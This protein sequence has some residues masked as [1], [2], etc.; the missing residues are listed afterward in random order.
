[1][2]SLLRVLALVLVTTSAVAIVAEQDVSAA[3]TIKAEHTDTYPWTP[4][5][6]ASGIAC[7]TCGSS[8]SWTAT[9]LIDPAAS[10]IEIRTVAVNEK[11]IRDP[12]DGRL[13]LKETT[14]CSWKGPLTNGKFDR[15]PGEC[16]SAGVGQWIDYKGPGGAPQNTSKKTPSVQ[17]GT[18]DLAGGKAK[19]D[20]WDSVTFTFPPVAGQ[21]GLK[22]SVEDG[23]AGVAADGRSEITLVAELPLGVTAD[24]ADFK[25]TSPPEAARSKR[26]TLTSKPFDKGKATATYVPPPSI[27]DP[28]DL[29]IEATVT[30]SSK[31]T[32]TGLVKLQVVQPPVVLVHGVWSNPSAWDELDALLKSATFKYVTRF[33]YADRNSGDPV[34][35]ARSLATAVPLDSK[36][37]VPAAATDRI[38]ASRYD[39][40][41][42]SLGGLII[43]QFISQ[44]DNYKRIRKVVT[45]GTP[46]LGSAFANWFLYFEKN[47]SAEA[48]VNNAPYEVKNHAN[49][50]SGYRSWTSDAFDWLKKQARNSEK[51]PMDDSFFKY[52]PAVEALA[53]DS[54]F[55]KAL[56]GDDSKAHADQIDYYF[57]YGGQPLIPASSSTE[58][59]KWGAEAT[60]WAS[61]EVMIDTF[62][63]HVAK[64]KTDGVVAEESAKGTAFTLPDGTQVAAL[65]FKPKK[66][67]AVSANHNNITRIAASEVSLAL[68]GL[69]DALSPSYT[70]GRLESPAHLH[71][72]DSQG[73]HV[74]LDAQG[75][76]ELGIPGATFSGPEEVTGA[77]ET[78]I[79]PGDEQVRFEVK[80]YKE[81][82]FG[83]TV[84][85]SA[86][87]ADRE[88]SFKGVPIKPGQTASLKP[89]SSGYA[90]LETP[91]GKVQPVAALVRA[92]EPSTSPVKDEAPASAQSSS[93]SGP[94]W[95]WWLGGGVVGAGLV[96]VGRRA[97]RGTTR[98]TAKDSSIHVPG[99]ASR[100]APLGADPPSAPQAQRPGPDTSHFCRHCGQPVTQEVRFCGS[101]GKD[102]R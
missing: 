100:A 101:C 90:E 60:S 53:I 59:K 98:A 81:G 99:P 67:K 4:L 3:D 63:D 85:R 77:P 80:G 72:Y 94:G 47:K 35:I 29:T 75:K 1:M 17:S 91:G 26:G 55:L 34:E 11:E 86:A 2:R 82:T 69:Q 88:V 28:F 24:K 10:T 31:K 6:K 38:L 49:W 62:F 7:D 92:V 42:H 33:S 19:V 15:I 32:Y 18:V 70:Y 58:W 65:P 46:H 25:I 16:V 87:D 61:N 97:R 43:R 36:G 12:T 37:H 96:L 66:T 79:V 95:L 45:L 13:H 27:M 8:S 83:L 68:E 102:V 40:V 74:G 21:G 54:P 52:G 57:F 78:I 30:D 64:A 84:R 71:A 50:K 39:L 22:L 56:N 76:P 41:G 44:G 23:W 89:Y 73:H 5:D 93:S 20:A 14:N 9:L 51:P 48:K